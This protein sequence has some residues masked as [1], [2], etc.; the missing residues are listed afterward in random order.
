[1]FI[2]LLATIYIGQINFPLNDDWNYAFTVMEYLQFGSIEVTTWTLT[3]A[4]TN[5]ILGILTCSLVGFSFQNL[6]IL[7]QAVSLLGCYALYLCLRRMSIPV[8]PSAFAAL[9]LLFNP[10]FFPLSH[11]FMTDSVFASLGCIY[12]FTCLFIGTR[13]PKRC[14]C[15]CLSAI[16]LVLSRQ[17]GI[18]LI[19]AQTVTELLNSAII[20]K[21]SKAKWQQR[22][23]AILP[24]TCSALALCSYY[25]WI[26]KEGFYLNSYTIETT[27]W[28]GLVASR[29]VWFSEIGK[30]ILIS[31]IYLGLFTLPVSICNLPSTINSFQPALRKFYLLLALELGISVSLGCFSRAACMPL[32]DN[33]LNSYGIGPIF[34]GHEAGI[35]GL[36]PIADSIWVFMTYMGILGGAMAASAIACKLLQLKTI[37]T[38]EY[39]V[40]EKAF[41]TCV[42]ATLGYGSWICVRGLYDRYLI[43]SVILIIVTVTVPICAR[44]HSQDK[45]STN[46]FFYFRKTNFDLSAKAFAAVLLSLFSY[47]SVIGT[48][49]YIDMNRA[50][51]HLLNEATDRRK[52]PYTKIDGGWEFNGWSFY[53]Q[54]YDCRIRPT[55][56]AKT[57]AKAPYIIS[58]AGMAGF[59]EISSCEFSR[60]LVPQQCKMRLLHRRD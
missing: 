20:S 60:Q 9:T 40:R 56:A 31:F 5:Y 3:T 11:S 52:I 8:G 7:T 15:V 2:Q 42:F 28:A 19:I 29:Q 33:V 24:A 4:V 21:S 41:I 10:L 55:Y 35:L 6:H 53:T 34:V 44:K 43:F 46:P 39:S 37:P 50:K 27:Y 26:I 51:W 58:L 13:T 48:R 1:M 36:H 38:A 16:A 49:D 59:D 30:N 12:L 54:S 22:G 32:C 17:V 18:A 57:M 47:F 14:L 23:L 45:L 25:C